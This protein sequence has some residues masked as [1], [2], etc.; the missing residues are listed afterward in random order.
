MPHFTASIQIVL[1]ARPYTAGRHPRHAVPLTDKV[2]RPMRFILGLL[3][4]CL[5]A[6]HARAAG[7]ESSPP[8]PFLWL[9][10]VHGARAMD[11]VRQQDA[12]SLGVLQAD[13]HYKPFYEAAL[14]I[15]DAKDRT[16]A[17]QQLGGQIYNFWQDATHVRGIWRRTSLADYRTAAPHWQTVLDIDALAAR[18]H[19][20]W[21]YKGANCREPEERLC[22]ILLSDGGE[23]A[24]VQREFD[25]ATD[26]FVKG[27]FDLPRAK[28]VADWQDDNTLYVVTDWGTGS[29]T[30]SGYP[31]IVKRLQRGQKLADATEV[32]RGKP[33]DVR[34]DVEALNDGQNDHYMLIQRSLD[35]FHMQFY[36]VAPSGLTQLRLPEKAEIEGLVHNHLVVKLDQAFTP[37]GKA[38]I[39][40][41][42]LIALD[43][44]HPDAAPVTIFAP[45]P[46]QSVDEAAV[47]H[48]LV[49]AAIYDNVR[50]SVRAF[51]SSGAGFSETTL[52]LP[53]NSSVELVSS[54]I[55]DNDGFFGVTGFLTPSSLWFGDAG[56][57]TPPALVKQS[58]ARFDASK[59][60][61][62]QFEATSTDGTKIPYFVVRPKDQKPDSKNPT[63]L[64]AYGGFQISMLPTYNAVLGK[65]WLENGGTYVLANIRGGGEF[66]PA[67][68][69]AALKTHRQKAFDDFA[70]VAKDLFA[71]HITSPA[72]LG[73]EGGSNGGLLMGVEFTQH[74]ALWDAVVIEVPLLDMLRFEKIAAGASWVGEYGSVAN[75][76]E[77]AFLAHISPYNNLHAGVKYPQPFIYT[78]T[79][80]DRVG[81]QHARKFAAK[82]AVLHVPFLYYEAIEGGHGAGVNAKEVAEERALEMTYLTGKLM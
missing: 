61:V 73:I 25:L 44:A 38:A 65:L 1:P 20:N 9:E 82:M 10:D 70:A 56:G 62:E 26:S 80:D 13:P 33:G 46:R 11:W 19:A 12:R 81:P 76:A 8:D 69:E 17:P 31:F 3:A 37:P 40:A 28:S 78:T 2:V 35:F 6:P 53:E 15:A 52:K 24:L 71:R 36:V 72:H 55:H 39:A 29:M 7:A 58:P 49:V 48:D 23:D 43:M 77:R 22:M 14:A 42:S 67:W 21:V 64:Y 18:E 34:V 54:D 63:L 16:P 57:T 41:G 68:H 51:A 27:G 5:L 30:D 47:T 59:D 74:P 79:K 75:P 45:G 32:F 60:V 4:L 50:G 66:G